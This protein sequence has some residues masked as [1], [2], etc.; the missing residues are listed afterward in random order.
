MQD[1]H[2]DIDCDQQQ[3]GISAVFWQPQLGLRSILYSVL[4]STLFL[5]PFPWFQAGF[6]ISSV[7][8][9]KPCTLAPPPNS[10]GG[11]TQKYPSI[12]HYFP[13]LP[14][15]YG[16]NPLLMDCRKCTCIPRT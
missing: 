10:V 11:W 15:F 8:V 14:G 7:T 2:T 4:L 13:N 16:G 3:Q 5:A 12:T 9:A 1:F 6:A